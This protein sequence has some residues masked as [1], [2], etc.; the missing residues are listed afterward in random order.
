MN[1]ARA[2]RTGSRRACPRIAVVGAASRPH[3]Q[4]CGCAAARRELSAANTSRA[5]GRPRTSQ[6]RPSPS[7][8]QNDVT[9]CA[10]S[11]PNHAPGMSAS[12]AAPAA[13]RPRSRPRAQAPEDVPARERQDADYAAAD[14]VQQHGDDAGRPGNRVVRA[15]HFA[16]TAIERFRDERER[17]DL[18]EHCRRQ[19]PAAGSARR[20]CPRCVRERHDRRDRSWRL[21]GRLEQP[22]RAEVDAPVVV[23]GALRQ[24]LRRCAIER[25]PARSAGTKVSGRRSAKQR[26]PSGRNLTVSSVVSP[27]ANRR[28]SIGTGR[29]R[30]R[31][32]PR[33]PPC[34]PSSST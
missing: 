27:G 24:R 28:T 15:A 11:K 18:D 25:G 5:R 1:A 4:S 10:V 34:P 12:E 31:P 3:R 16:E 22:I 8:N 7:R 21:V 19:P 29:R 32:A 20:G 14:P 2:A 23:R 6:P 26:R 17:R 9:L 30:R 13:H 33:T